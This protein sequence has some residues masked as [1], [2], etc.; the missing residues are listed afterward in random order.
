MYDYDAKL[1]E[2]T[3]IGTRKWC[4]E[5]RLLVELPKVMDLHGTKFRHV[6]LSASKTRE[7]YRFT[8]LVTRA[9][10]VLAQL[11]REASRKRS[12]AEKLAERAAGRKGREG[13]CQICGHMQIIKKGLLVLHG[14]ERPGRGY[15]TGRCYGCSEL[16]FEVSCDA[17]KRWI[18]ILGQMVAQREESLAGLGART[19]VLRA[20]TYRSG[21]SMLIRK[22]EDA[23]AFA[24]EIER[25]K[26]E[27]ESEIRGIES[28]IRMQ[29][30]RLADWKPAKAAGL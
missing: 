21:K 7:G 15:I 5:V 8:R 10:K 14:Y 28:D 4:G 24:N 18:G 26:R 12:T 17:L 20:P 23:V 19:E 6:E 1:V 11:G 22:A 27:L 29:N 25:I 3:V 9:M 2:V 13:T 30:A 16:P